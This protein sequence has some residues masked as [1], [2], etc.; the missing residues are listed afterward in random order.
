MKSLLKAATASVALLFATA[1]PVVSAQ[2]QAIEPARVVV[3]DMNRV[4]ATSAAGQDAQRQLNAQSDRLQNQ[5]KTLQAQFQKEEE[6]L[7]KKRSVIAEDAFQQEVGQF[8]A[9]A[10]RAQSDLE[11][12]QNDLRRAAAFVNDQIMR[13]LRPIVQEVMTQRQA[14]IVVDASQV[15]L[16]TPAL[17]VT[18]TVIERLNQRLPKVSTTPPPATPAATQAPAAPAPRR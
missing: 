9:R 18:A 15:F 16:N 14:N 10:A 7:A 6:A 5:L 12:Q 13:G 11:R 2:A 1:V 17:D 3:V 4:F 8:R